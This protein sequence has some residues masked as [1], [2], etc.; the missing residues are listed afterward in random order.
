MKALQMLCKKVSC[1]HFLKG[2]LPGLRQ[3][4]ATQDPLK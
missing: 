1:L 3:F 2:A 4:L